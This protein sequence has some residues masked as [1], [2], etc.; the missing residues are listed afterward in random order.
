MSGSVLQYF[1]RLMISELQNKNALE[2]GTIFL[3]FSEEKSYRFSCGLAGRLS[4]EFEPFCIVGGI[5]RC[6]ALEIEPK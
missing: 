6:F 4:A 5:I 3:T 2:P 1:T